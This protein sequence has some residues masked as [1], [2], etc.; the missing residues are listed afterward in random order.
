MVI[1]SD[2]KLDGFDIIQTPYKTIGNHEIRTDILVPRA[3]HEGKRPVLVRIHGGG[4]VRTPRRTK[5]ARM[6]S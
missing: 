4:L 2:P 1:P 5:D 3:A 6:P